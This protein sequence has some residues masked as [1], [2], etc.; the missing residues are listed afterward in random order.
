[1]KLGRR[2]YRWIEDGSAWA[3][4]RLHDSAYPGRGGNLPPI[5]LVTLPKAGSIF[6]HTALRRTL[7][8][9]MLKIACP[10]IHEQ[11]IDHRRLARFARG[12]AVCREHFAARDFLLDG[13]RLAGIR[14]LT[15]HVRDPR[16]A[17]LSW[18]RNMERV[19]ED[20]GPA[21][22][23][24]DN[25]QRTPEAYFGW[26]FAQRL[27]WQVDH[28]LPR[29]VSWIQDWMDTIERHAGSGIAFKVTTYE[30]FAADNRS[31]VEDLL[32]F[33]EIKV[34]DSWLAIPRYEV[35]K[36]NVFHIS[37][38]STRDEMGETLY[39]RASAMVPEAL[40]SRFGWPTGSAPA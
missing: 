9:P 26:S 22:L 29:Y 35:G 39:A 2:L 4:D 1:L 38:K 16:A 17:V 15:V 19:L 24:L 11:T 21:A 3:L 40:I 14:K 13:L 33:Y 32:A 5:M 23:V 31:F 25:E 18:T 30:Q 27:E 34:E 28:Q 20:D 36:A 8:V 37:R 7:R 12:N 6:I 10:G